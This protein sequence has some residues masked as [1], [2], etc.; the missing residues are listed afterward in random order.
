MYKKYNLGKFKICILV[1]ERVPE[2]R[3]SSKLQY[4]GKLDLKQVEQGFSSFFAKFLL[5][6]L[7]IFQSGVH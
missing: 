5:R 7:V 6:N 4:H 2:I 3:V 1:A